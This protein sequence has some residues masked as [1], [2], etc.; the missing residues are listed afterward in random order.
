MELQAEIVRWVAESK[1]PFQVVSDRGFQSLMKTGR[2]EYYIPSP[3]TVSR[4][5]RKVFANTQKHIANMLQEYEGALSF[6]TDAWTS[7]NHRAFIAMTVHF[8]QDGEPVCLIL[9]VVK[10]AMSH[11]GANLAAAFAKILDEFGVSDKVSLHLK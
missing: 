5:V 3:T 6:A 10:V 8:E 1:R 7:P 11:S 4:D 2:P 9:D